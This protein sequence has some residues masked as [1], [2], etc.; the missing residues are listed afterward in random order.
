MVSFIIS[1]NYSVTGVR[2]GLVILSG[3]LSGVNPG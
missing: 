3:D 1:S 2:L